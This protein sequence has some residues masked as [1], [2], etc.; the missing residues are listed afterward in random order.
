MQ[1]Y[2][3]LFKPANAHVLMV[4]F[5]LGGVGALMIGLQQS[6]K[7]AEDT[8]R[9]ALHIIGMAEGVNK[10]AGM[11]MMLTKKGPLF[12]ADTTVNFNP[13][14]EELAEITLLVKQS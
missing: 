14:A 1:I 4:S 5:L 7:T 11:Y 3:R 13:T 10:I 8:I 9:P 6:L 2:K 12:M